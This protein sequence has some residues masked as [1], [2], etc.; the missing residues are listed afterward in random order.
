MSKPP[1]FI[2]GCASDAGLRERIASI[3]FD[4]KSKSAVIYFEKA[5]AVKTALMV[6]AVSFH[7]KPGSRTDASVM[8]LNGGTLNDAHLTVTSDAVENDEDEPQPP[9]Q[10]ASIDQ[11]D[12]PRAASACTLIVTTGWKPI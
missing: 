11:T 5:P 7:G 6:G 8:Q 3:S 10:R 4:E 12:K 2:S 1:A 9:T